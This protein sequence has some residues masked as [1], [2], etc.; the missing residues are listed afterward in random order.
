ML[1]DARWVTTVHSA[2]TVAFSIGN[3]LS[4][5]DVACAASD[6]E[7]GRRDE[8]QRTQRDSANLDDDG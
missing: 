2:S 3:D 1:C 5:I 4:A 7:R 8:T 6:A